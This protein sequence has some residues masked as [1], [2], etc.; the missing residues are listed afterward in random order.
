MAVALIMKIQCP[1]MV[2]GQYNAHCTIQSI[3]WEELQNGIIFVYFLFFKDEDDEMGDSM[4]NTHWHGGSR[5]SR[6]P[7]REDHRRGSHHSRG[8]P[9]VLLLVV[10]PLVVGAFTVLSKMVI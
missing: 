4:G 8:A 1:A 3:R 6:D 10:L 9:L 7:R 5:G 2:V